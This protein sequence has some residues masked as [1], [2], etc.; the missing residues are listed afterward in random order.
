MMILFKMSCEQECLRQQVV[1]DDTEDWQ[2]SPSFSG[3][4]RVGGVDLSFI[5]GD[6][7]NAC[8]QLVVLSYPDLK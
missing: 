2:R 8:A 4:E 5:K 3:L 1:E 6:E 7:V